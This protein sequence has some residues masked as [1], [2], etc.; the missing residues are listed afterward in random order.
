MIVIDENIGT[1][2]RA[3]RRVRRRVDARTSSCACACTFI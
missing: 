3:P 2:R 1:V